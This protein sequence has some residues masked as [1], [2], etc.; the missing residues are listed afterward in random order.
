MIAQMEVCPSC[1]KFLSEHRRSFRFGNPGA[2]PDL[3]LGAFPVLPEEF[4]GLPTSEE[5]QIYGTS[6]ASNPPPAQNSI[7]VFANSGKGNRAPGRKA[8]LLS[9]TI[10]LPLGSEDFP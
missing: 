1:G 4:Q 8:D 9:V 6:A 5:V 3:V 2:C 7:G 10:N